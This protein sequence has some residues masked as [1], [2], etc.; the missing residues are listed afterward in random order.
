M[1]KQQKRKKLTT[2]FDDLISG[3]NNFSF[4]VY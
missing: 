3:L 4:Y 1:A 2:D